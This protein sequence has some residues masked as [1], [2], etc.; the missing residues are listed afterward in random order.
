MKVAAPYVL[1]NMSALASFVSLRSLEMDFSSD[2]LSTQMTRC[3]LIFN[4]LT[5]GLTVLKLTYLPRIDTALLAQVASRFPSLATL[6][7][8]SAERLDE[9]CCWLCFQESSSC[10]LHSPIPDFFPSVEALAV[11][12][13][14]LSIVLAVDW[15]LRFVAYRTPSARP[16]SLSRTLSIY[17]WASS[18]RTLMCSTATSTA[19]P[20]SSYPLPGR[21]SIPRHLLGPTSASSALLNI[22]PLSESGSS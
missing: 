14:P 10:I 18:F 8:S 3:S 20:L 16:C 7:L 9:E 17:S 12:M 11:R 1:S 13:R 19:A 15:P 21:A 5:A 22:A 2:G 4:Q 6:E